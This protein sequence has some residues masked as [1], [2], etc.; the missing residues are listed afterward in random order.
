MFEVR[1]KAAEQKEESLQKIRFE[2]TACFV[3]NSKGM[4]NKKLR[5]RLNEI[6]MGKMN[7]LIA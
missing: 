3:D 2:A 7:P 5:L 4:I 1:M 6:I